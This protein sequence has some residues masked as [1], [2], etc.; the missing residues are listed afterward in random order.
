MGFVFF[1][2]IILRV[3]YF[4]PDALWH[5]WRYT[6]LD[7]HKPY[8]LTLS[9]NERIGVEHRPDLRWFFLGQKRQTNSL[10]FC[11][12]PRTREELAGNPTLA[13]MGESFVESAGLPPE[14][15]FGGR[16]ERY[17]SQSR[18]I[19]VLDMSVTNTVLESQIELLKEKVIRAYRPRWVL[20]AFLAYGNM[21]E[22]VAARDIW[23]RRIETAPD[24]WP[25]W[26]RSFALYILNDYWSHIDWNREWLMAKLAKWTGGSSK[27]T[28]PK[29]FQT[30]GE[31]LR[32]PA[33]DGQDRSRGDFSKAEFLLRELKELGKKHGFEVILSPLSHLKELNNPARDRFER[34]E[35]ETIARKLDLPYIDTYPFLDGEDPRVCILW[36]ANR[37]PNEYG[38]DLMTK[39][40]ARALID[41]GLLSAKDPSAE[42]PATV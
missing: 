7:C 29:P 30:R 22:K 36:A 5:F 33:A 26:K 27:N 10:G 12:R 39:G 42:K 15:T 31:A 41:R 37:H 23:R 17:L 28:A 20:V 2:E 3:F 21:N 13:V 40:L 32:K 9:E 14:A 1:S 25:L 24:F 38:Y 4:G 11:D 8:F 19:N 6:P 35:L 34:S 18:E 16:L